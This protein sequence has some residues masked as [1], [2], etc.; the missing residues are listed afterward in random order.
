[1][2]DLGNISLICPT[3][4]RPHNVQRLIESVERTSSGEIPVFIK[5]YIDDDDETLEDVK[6]LET[7]K[8]HITLQVTVGPRILMCEMSNILARTAEEG[9]LFFCGDDI[10][11]ESLDW[12]LKVKEEFKKYSDRILLVYGD[13]GHQGEALATHFFLHSNWVKTLG[14]MVP[15]LFT[16]DWVDNYVTTISKMLDRKVYINDMKTIHYHPHAGK[17]IMD[18]TYVAK[19]LRDQNSAPHQIFNNSQHFRDNDCAK[20]KEFINEKN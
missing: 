10:V 19:Y 14:Y 20:L 17:A 1:M 6:R 18:E 7:C 11:M 8:E 16:G 12:D 13:D 4:K 2:G 5:F 9:I 3:R 15:P